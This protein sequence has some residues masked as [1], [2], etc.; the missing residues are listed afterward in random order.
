MVKQLLPT[1]QLMLTDLLPVCIVE[2]R[3]VRGMVSYSTIPHSA[4]QTVLDSTVQ[5][6]AE[7]CSAEQYRT[8]RFMSMDD[9]YMASPDRIL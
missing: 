8:V 9:S 6:S 5:C 2:V 7:R 1:A 4:V 3:L